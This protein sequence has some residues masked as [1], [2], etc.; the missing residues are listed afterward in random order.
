MC[1]RP[2]QRDA[3]ARI[4]RVPPKNVIRRSSLTVTG[5]LSAAGRIVATYRILRRKEGKKTAKA[6]GGLEWTAEG[7]CL[8]RSLKIERG[9]NMASESTDWRANKSQCVY[10]E[11]LCYTISYRHDQ[12]RM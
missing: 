7:A 11:S 9:F 4:V 3:N 2:P 10:V 5:W 1:A 12:P 8:G 6:N